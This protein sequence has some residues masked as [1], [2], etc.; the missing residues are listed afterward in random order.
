MSKDLGSSEGE[1]YRGGPHRRA[2]ETKQPSSI[3]DGEVSESS[4]A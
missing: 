4:R 2:S 3:A 1:L